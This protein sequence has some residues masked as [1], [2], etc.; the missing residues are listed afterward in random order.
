M[1]RR[2]YTEEERAAVN[3]RRELLAECARMVEEERPGDIDRAACILAGYSRR[4]IA[5]I[6]LQAEERGRSFPQAVAGFHQ[7]RQAG[8]IV[9]KGAKGYAIWAP[10]VR[11]GDAPEDGPSGFTV[12][13]VFDVIDTEPLAENS[14]VTLAELQQAS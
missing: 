10:I 9:R 11:K 13:H 3:A 7:W 4:N 1:G 6:L 5:L 2:S 12:R 8:R 14:P